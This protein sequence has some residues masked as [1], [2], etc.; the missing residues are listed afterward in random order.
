[1]EKLKINSPEPAIFLLSIAMENPTHGVAGGVEIGIGGLYYTKDGYN[2][3]ESI[4]LGIITTQAVYSMGK[5]KYA[6]VGDIDGN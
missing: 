5:N 6:F 4:Q 1:V 3:T 2:F